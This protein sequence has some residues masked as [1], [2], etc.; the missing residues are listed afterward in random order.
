MKKI[1]IITLPLHNNYGG[2]LQAFALTTILK[3]LNYLPFILKPT[4]TS[5]TSKIKYLIDKKNTFS[6][7]KKQFITEKEINFPISKEE[8]ENQGIN[9]IIVGSDQ[10]WRPLFMDYKISF[11][12][13]ALNSNI[14]C[15]SYAASFG[16]DTWEFN[17]KQTSEIR[18]YI[19][20]FKAISVREE[21]GVNLCKDYLHIDAKHVL[22]PTMLLSVDHYNKFLSK[23]SKTYI[24]YYILDYKD[25]NNKKIIESIK[26]LYAIPIKTTK[27]SKNKVLK[28]IIPQPSISQWLNYIYNAQIVIT[29]SF[30]GCVFCILFHKD[31]YVLKNKNGGNARIYSL[32]NMF[33]LKNRLITS[34]LQENSPI[35]WDEVE[36]ILQNKRKESM[37][38]IKNNLSY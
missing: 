14:S 31:F 19:K 17:K 30:H 28:R 36:L 21:S 1:G 3:E 23:K 35:N 12:S 29:D 20:N 18:Q 16:V 5:F 37:E 11:C 24:Y 25:K 9:L 2:V 4:S 27:L 10:V 13:F 38:F 15:I 26:S 8:L 32:L 34:T 6:H 7:F 33:N 22:D